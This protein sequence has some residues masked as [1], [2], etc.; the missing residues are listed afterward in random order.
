MT[1]STKSTNTN[2]LER[3]MNRQKPIVPSRSDVV[4]EINP[5]NSTTLSGQDTNISRNQEL[6]TSKCQDSKTFRHQDFT[7]S[8]LEDTNTSTHQDSILSTHQQTSISINP[9][10]FETV[11]NTTRIESNVD[12]ALRN[13]CQQNKITKE[14]WFEAAYLYLSQQPEAMDE[15]IELASQRLS[16]RKQIADH[17]RAVAMQKRLIH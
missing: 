13:F 2:A 15:V 11:R 9:D 12:Q 16:E 6:T 3:L 8:K 5:Q 17:R 4:N 7:T 1:Q 10:E 14:T